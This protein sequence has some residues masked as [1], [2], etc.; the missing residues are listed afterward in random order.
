[1]AAI[2]AT[3]L[4]PGLHLGW[5]DE[6]VP[7]AVFESDEAIDVVDAIARALP[8]ADS[9]A[10]STIALT[11]PDAHHTFDRHVT[12]DA[13]RERAAL[14]RCE[15][16]GHVAAAVSDLRVDANLGDLERGAF[17]PAA[18]PTTGPLWKRVELCVRKVPIGQ[19]ESRVAASLLALG[20]REEVNGIGFDPRRLAGGVHDQ[21]T[22]LGKKYADPV[23]ELMVFAALVLFPTRGDGRKIRQ[24]GWRGARSERGGFEWCAW[25][26]SLDRWA[27]DALLDVDAKLSQ[28]LVLA[29]YRV[30]PYQK[31]GSSDL[32]RAYFAERIR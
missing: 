12:L 31:S 3:V 18:P 16:S 20:Q 24:R 9:L 15:G 13:Y 21:H 25:R 29:R 6:A 23:I 32:T 2:G 1:L 8:T 26:P 7:F 4:V 30:V 10:R 22:T 17:Y 19:R 11:R 5:A 14:E 27:I 28:E